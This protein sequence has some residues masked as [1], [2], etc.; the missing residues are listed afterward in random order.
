[1]SILHELVDDPLKNRGG[2]TKHYLTLFS[3]VLGL[4]A[5]N[6]LEIGG[7]GST[8]VILEALKITGGKLTTCDP[9]EIEGIGYTQTF[10]QENKN[11]N[12]VQDYSYN[13]L[14]KL[15]EDFD[16][17]LHDGSHEGKV[18]FKDLRN[19][20]PH[21]KK[22]GI[23]LVHDTNHEK[24]KNLFLATRLALL[25]VRHERITLPYGFGL[26]VIVKK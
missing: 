7:G 13:L 16:L 12:F 3:F 18:L 21:V 17:V 23:V 1:M 10:Q 20:F 11:W 26:T 9:R 4:E 8:A 15:S 25:G 14:P 6:V 2:F 19:I 24:L 22:G 5:K